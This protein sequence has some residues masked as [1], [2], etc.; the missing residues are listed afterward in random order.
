MIAV[1]PFCPESP[2]WLSSKDKFDE[3]ERILMDL[4]QL[5]ITHPYVAREMAEIRAEV[6]FQS[7]LE[8]IRP[9]FKNKLKD[10]FKKGIRNRIAIGLCLMM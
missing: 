7:Y 1:L 6:E 8:S 2:R 4:R 10:L 9:G 5:P 3:A